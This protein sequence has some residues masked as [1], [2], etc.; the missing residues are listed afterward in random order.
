MGL[1]DVEYFLEGS[2][3]RTWNNRKDFIPSYFLRSFKCFFESLFW[4]LVAVIRESEMFGDIIDNK[5]KFPLAFKYFIK[6]LF[7]SFSFNL[8][9]I[10]LAEKDLT[11]NFIEFEGDSDNLLDFFEGFIV[12]QDC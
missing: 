5:E 4:R 6:E 12:L 7:Q 8:N 11:T 10:V 2:V 3:N 1:K 9:E